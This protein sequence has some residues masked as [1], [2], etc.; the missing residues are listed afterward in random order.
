[1]KEKFKLAGLEM[2]YFIPITLVLIAAIA[3]GK[4]PKGMLGAFPILI[5]IG[6]IFDYIGNKTPIVKDYLGGGPI[7]EL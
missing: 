7:V 3:L 4:L 5:V 2:K 1:M 6:A